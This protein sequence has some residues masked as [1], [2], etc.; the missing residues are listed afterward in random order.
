VTNLYPI[1]PARLAGNDGDDP[2]PPGADETGLPEQHRGQLRFAERFTTTYD[3]K[4][5]H[6][7]GIGWHQFDGARWAPCLDGAETRAMCAMVKQALT[8]LPHLDKDA[9]GQLYKD[10]TRMESNAAIEGA[11]ALAGRLHPCTIAG[12]ALDAD[13]QLLN[14][15]SGTVE[16]HTGH[17]RSA[18]PHDYLSK[19]TRGRFDPTACSDAF[20]NFL[21][22]IQP[23][24]TMRA[25]LA[26]SLGSALLGQV[27]EHVLLI[28]HGVG[29][30]G[31]G[32]LRDAVRHALGDYAVEVPADIL[33]WS[34]YGQQGLAPERMRLRG[35]RVAFC[36]EIAAGAK[37]DEAT[38]KKLTG[39]DPVTAKL[40]YR[41]PIEFDPSHTILMLTNHLPVVRG[42]DPAVWRRIL[43][44]PFATVV[45]AEARDSD[46]P[47]K[48]KAC[49]D[50][51]LAWLWHGWRDYQR[52]GL[53]PPEAVR[54]ATEKYR[55]DSDV[56]ARFLA[57]EGTVIHGH[58]RVPAPV[59]YQAFKD[60]TRAE[61]EPSDVS[62]RAFTEALKLR[63]Y[64]RKHTES[65][66]V[67][68]HLMLAQRNDRGDLW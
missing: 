49:P 46:L 30:N 6:V 55:L 36:S 26:R 38:M 61:G 23:D 31:K 66:N 29:A 18:D 64:R 14:T 41:N 59:L 68:E 35:A 62:N 57:D 8:E 37:L 60:W 43:A 44:V 17:Q 5:V 15:A 25:F 32:T 19:V 27:R 51:V 1:R 48:L 42:D 58:G 21:I 7:H 16:L 45:P 65:G 22:T 34:K 10:I 53:N 4:F 40:L 24:P 50:A 13:V 33:L 54:A 52:G 2:G 39:G 9:R 47:S 20:D 63:G 67:W 56:L 3:G 11:L 28:W 12:A